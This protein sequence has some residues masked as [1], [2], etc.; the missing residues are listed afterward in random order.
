M[1]SRLLFF[2]IK[3]LFQTL[4]VSGILEN[5]AVAMAGFYK[6]IEAFGETNP[7]RTGPSSDL[8]AMIPFI[9]LMLILYMTGREKLLAPKSGAQS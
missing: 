3:E 6:S 1:L 7:L 9:L 2:C 5:Q 4:L 8:L